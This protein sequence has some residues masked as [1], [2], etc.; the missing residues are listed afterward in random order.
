MKGNNNYIFIR[1][2]LYKILQIFLSSD[3]LYWRELKMFFLQTFSPKLISYRYLNTMTTIL[4]YI[5][6]ALSILFNCTF[7]FGG[8]ISRNKHWVWISETRNYHYLNLSNVFIFVII[9]ITFQLLSLPTLFRYLSVLIT[10]KEY[11][12]QFKIL[13]IFPDWQTPEKGYVWI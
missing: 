10:F 5:Y 8:Y 2:K 4:F 9:I 7:C 13:W 11:R 1:I 12:V 3:L 6:H